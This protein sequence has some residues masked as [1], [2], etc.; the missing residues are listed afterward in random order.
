MEGA[1]RY[2]EQD[3]SG[4]EPKNRSD[5]FYAGSLLYALKNYKGAVENYSMMEERTDSI[6]Q[7][8]NYHLGFSQVQLKDKVSALGAFRDAAGQS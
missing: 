4:K 6:G 3:L 1:N 7:I 5:Y 8:A 2:Y